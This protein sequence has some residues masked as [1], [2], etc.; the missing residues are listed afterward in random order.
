METDFNAGIIE[1]RYE[2]I[3]AEDPHGIGLY[4]VSFV[5]REA[6]KSNLQPS[7]ETSQYIRP[8]S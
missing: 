5:P 6:T 2:V 3:V 7:M 1:N 4:S 8:L